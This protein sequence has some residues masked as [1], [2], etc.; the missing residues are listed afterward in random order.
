MYVDERLVVDLLNVAKKLL[1][2]V[3]ALP[4]PAE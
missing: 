4:S 2:A 1:E 3:S